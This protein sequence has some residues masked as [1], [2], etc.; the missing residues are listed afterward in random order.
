MSQYTVYIVPDAFQEI[1][2]LP[3]NVRQRVRAAIRDLVDNPRS[4]QSKQ[5]DFSEFAGE[6]RR[7]RLDNWRILYAVS[8]TDRVVDVLAVRKRPPYDYGD[9]TALLEQLE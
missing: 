7:L 1:K 2:Q 6:L 4:P 9:L 3:G 8:E 5:L